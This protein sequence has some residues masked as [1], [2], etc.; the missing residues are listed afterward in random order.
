MVV[1]TEVMIAPVGGD[2]QYYDEIPRKLNATLS[3]EVLSG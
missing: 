2:R 3:P 1:A